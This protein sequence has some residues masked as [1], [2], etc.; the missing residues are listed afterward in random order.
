MPE[1]NTWLLVSSLIGGTLVMAYRMRE[2]S[3][4][5]TARKII[6]P[7]LGMSTGFG[8]FLYPPA[9]IPPLWA[10][11]AFLL[12]ALVLSYP[13]VKT[14]KLTRVGDVVMLRRSRAFLWIL[15]GLISIRI[16]LR[17]YVG[18]YVDP[19]QTASLFFVLAFGMI[20]VWRVRMLL[21]YRELAPELLQSKPVGGSQLGDKRASERSLSL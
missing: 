10:L 5:I 15:V 18:Q 12:G 16:G 8:M 11:A 7:P 6:I 4:P 21:E 14:S 2:S 3:R 13:L 19:I 9:R 1:L 20:A 17:T